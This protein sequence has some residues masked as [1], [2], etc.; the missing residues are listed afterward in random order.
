MA[1]SSCG[2]HFNLDDVSGNFAQ[3]SHVFSYRDFLLQNHSANVK[4]NHY[5]SKKNKSYSDFL[6]E[7]KSKKKYFRC[8]LVDHWVKNCRNSVICFRCK[9]TGHKGFGCNFSPIS[10]PKSSSLSSESKMKTE[11]GHEFFF[12]SIGFDGEIMRASSWVVISIVRGEFTMFQIVE[13]LRVNFGESAGNW[14]WEV[15]RLNDDFV[16]RFP[17]NLL[18]KNTLDSIITASG[19]LNLRR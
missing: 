16:A 3:D 12:S 6:S 18:N 17:P 13:L 11:R 1:S 8:G 15:K 10:K 7:V 2:A 14:N 5:N 19:I 9:R 4:R